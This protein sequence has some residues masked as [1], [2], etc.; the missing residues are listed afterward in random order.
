MNGNMTIGHISVF[1]NTWMNYTMSHYWKHMNGKDG[2][3]TAMRIRTIERI[4]RICCS[5]TVGF[6][7]RRN[8]TNESNQCSRKN[9]RTKTR[10]DQ[11]RTTD[12]IAAMGTCG[13]YTSTTT[14]KLT[15][16]FF[17]HICHKDYSI[18]LTVK[19]R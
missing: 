16:S 3:Q 9:P 12:S 8:L 4:R 6:G 19:S 2:H 5:G 1:Q 17:H 10:R 11:K 14:R 13:L 15:F 7:A 18:I